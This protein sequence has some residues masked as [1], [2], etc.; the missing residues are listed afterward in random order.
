ML[1]T[2]IEA[3]RQGGTEWILWLLICLST[4]SLTIILERALFHWR[5]RIDIDHIGPRVDALLARGDPT[6]AIR[7]LRQYPSME[8]EVSVQVLA[9][10]EWPSSALEDLYRSVL[11]TE[12]LRYEARIGFLATVGSNAPFIGLFGTV[13]GIVSAF[14][15]LSGAGAGANR[16]QV[17]MQS[18][19]EA[20]VATAVGIVVAIPAVMAYNVFQRRTDRAAGA[21]EAMVRSIMARLKAPGH[22]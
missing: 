13:L 2:V 18:I 1:Q 7:V 5:R 12:R 9:H 16:A 11:E 4:V 21:A 15:D 19:S 17:I 10:A 20:L 6:E 22:S 8:S 14:S 3:L